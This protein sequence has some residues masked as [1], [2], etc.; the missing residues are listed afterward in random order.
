MPSYCRVSLKATTQPTC[1]GFLKQSMVASTCVVNIFGWWV[2]GLKT[3]TPADCAKCKQLA[4]LIPQ[5]KSVPISEG[6]QLIWQDT[7]HGPM[8]PWFQKKGNWCNWLSPLHQTPFAL[9]NRG[10]IKD[11][12]RFSSKLKTRWLG[13]LMTATLQR[14]W[15]IKSNNSKEP[16]EVNSVVDMLFIFSG[17]NIYD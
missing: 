12:R 11:F 16:H 9:Q 14:K 7:T 8:V 17:K 1:S 15:A 3:G 2:C 4:N 13:T 6:I 5:D 10:S